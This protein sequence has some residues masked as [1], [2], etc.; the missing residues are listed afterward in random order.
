[1]MIFQVVFFITVAI[2]CIICI[3]SDLTPNTW[4]YWAIVCGLIIANW[5]GLFSGYYL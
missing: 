3:E 4:Q 5:C 1:M 2:V